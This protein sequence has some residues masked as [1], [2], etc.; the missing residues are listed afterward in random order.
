MTICF[1]SKTGDLLLMIHELLSHADVQQKRAALWTVSLLCSEVEKATR[2]MMAPNVDK[3]ERN[4]AMRRLEACTWAFCKKE[5]KTGFLVCLTD[6][7]QPNLPATRWC[8]LAARCRCWWRCAC[9][10]AC[11]STSS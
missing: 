1:Q 2:T 10:A 4:L 7:T 3:K 5:Q 6:A 11:P 9:C 8:G